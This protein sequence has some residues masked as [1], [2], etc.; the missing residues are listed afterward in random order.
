MIS[1]RY[2][3]VKCLLLLLLSRYR[4]TVNKVSRFSS[5]LDLCPT[6]WSRAK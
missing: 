3:L 1:T 2:Q 4:F 6:A 5:M